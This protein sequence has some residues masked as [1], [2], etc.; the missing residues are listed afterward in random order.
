MNS[1]ALE[2]KLAAILS[3]DVVGY[4]RLMAEDEA[5]TI[6][7]LTDYR[8][9]IAMLV[10]QHR[11]RVVDSPGDN[12]LAEFPTA[13]DAVHGAIE[14]QRVLQA[15][16]ADLPTERKM[17]F[18]LG[19]HLGDVAVEGERIYGD[20]VNIAARLEGLAEP[21]GICVSATV[22]EQVRNKLEVAYEDLG[23]RA[24]KN[25][26]DQVR[27]Y[28]VQLAG[29]RSQL[30]RRAGTRRRRLR[31]AALAGGV[32]VLLV[33]AAVVLTWPLALGPILDLA[34]VSGPPLNPPLPDK[35][36]VVV[37]PFTN[38]SGDPEQEYFSDGITEDLTTDLSRNPFLFVIARNSA[39]SYKG[40]P[41]KVEDVGRELGVRY[42]LEGSVRRAEGRVR[43]TAQLIDAST[44]FHVWSERY[45]RE[46]A[47]IF[48]LQSE[49]SEKILAAVGL[50]IGEAELERIRRKPTN[51][52]TAYDL[53]QRGLFHFWRFTREGNAQARRLVERALELDP[54]FAE[55]YALLGATYSTEFGFGWN[56]DP[57]LLDRAEELARRGLAVNPSMPNPH[58]SLA[59]IHIFRGEPAA[60]VAASR[61]AIEL[62]PSLFAPHLFLGFALAQQG[63]FVGAM[64]SIN[65][66][67]RLNPRA[68]SGFGLIVPWVNLAAGRKQE[69]VELFEQIRVANPELIGARTPL[70]AIY[71]L[72]GRH[73]EARAIAQEILHVNPH[74]SA[75]LAVEFFAGILPAETATEYRDALR[76]AGLP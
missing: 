26:P 70:A 64:Q 8:E 44:G 58:L 19:V 71:E 27:V 35:P 31:A 62:G 30:P 14:I 16:N 69:A 63:R 34:G 60:A 5:A 2:R 75:E 52:L 47:D 7:T 11:G 17:E 53:F 41:V 36:S 33:V 24:I 13:L 9:A 68:P 57:K 10:R 73:E 65:R 22:H 37:L 55:A 49:I 6:R 66:G 72:E 50:E 40:K 18:R 25:I 46:L 4:S 32:G 38:L 20:G 23:D 39:F 51:D 42:V 59:A 21:G 28:R 12:L 1:D 67:L 15:R 61:R 54:D 43:I 76:R 45:D 3:A 29:V 48:A 56:L 74:L